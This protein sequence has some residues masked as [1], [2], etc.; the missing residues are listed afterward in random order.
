MT[1]ISYAQNYED[2]MLY[3]ALKDVGKGFYID[4]GACD[5]VVDSVTKAFYERGWRGINIEPVKKWFERLVEDRPE[6]INLQI[7]ISNEPGLVRLYEVIDTGL[8]TLVPE[9]AEKHRQAGFQIQEYFV[10]ALTLNSICNSYSVSEIHFLKIDVEGAEGAVLASVDLERFRP[11]I[12]LVEATEP[13]STIENFKGWESYLTEHRYDFVYFDGV[14]RFYIAKERQE[15][16]SAFNAPPNVFDGF[17]RYSEWLARQRAVQ[18]EKEISNS[19]QQASQLQKEL[20]S[21]RQRAARLEEELSNSRQHAARV[22]EE[23]RAVY[24]SRSWQITKPLRWVGC[25]VRDVRQHLRIYLIRV[26]SLPKRLAK[27]FLKRFVLFVIKTTTLKSIALQV[28][29]R[30]PTFKA[31]LK[32]WISCA[33]PGIML[34]TETSESKLY[35]VCQAPYCYHNTRYT[36]R[37]HLISTIAERV[38]NDLKQAIEREWR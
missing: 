11:W 8:S 36:S 6:D 7:A 10:P 38:Y 17:I 23:L 5:P 35:N 31:R 9:V 26:S 1:F 22:E 3:R 15:L 33:I 14:N 28:L 18:L 19:R 20:E 12:I 24:A 2:V 29:N 32:C 37:H 13:N 34:D 27:G 16:K 21:F 30:F 25:I 4:V